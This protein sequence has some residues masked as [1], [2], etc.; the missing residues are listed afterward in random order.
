MFLSLSCS[1]ICSSVC[2]WSNPNY[3]RF[4]SPLKVFFDLA[5]HRHCSFSKT[6]YG[7]AFVICGNTVGPFLS[8]DDENCSLHCHIRKDLPSN[9]YTFRIRECLIVVSLGDSLNML[10]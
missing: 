9:K 7:V 5:F 8:R 1:F 3:L 6:L 2:D 10:E 4:E